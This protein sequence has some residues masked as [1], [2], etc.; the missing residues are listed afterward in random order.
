M[1]LLVYL[2]DN[3]SVYQEYYTCHGQDAVFVAKEVYKTS[4]V[5]KYLG[6]G[7]MLHFLLFKFD[8]RKINSFEVYSFIFLSVITV[9]KQFKVMCLNQCL[10]QSHL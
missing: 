6:S 1:L 3:M 8:E 9:I 4:G 7:M 2:N 5:V 10:N